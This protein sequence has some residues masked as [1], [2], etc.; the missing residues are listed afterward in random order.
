[1]LLNC[2]VEEDSWEFLG[3]QENKSVL[4]EINPEDS[5]E[6]LVL[7]LKLQ[8]F[9]HLMWRAYSLEKTLILGKTE[10]KR[11]RGQQKINGW[12]ASLTEWTWIWANS[13][14]QWR[15]GEPGMLQF[16]GSQ[17]VGHDLA[18]EQQCDIWFPNSQCL[19]WS[20][21]ELHTGATEDL[22]KVKTL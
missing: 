17:G 15:T 12:M 10:V 3:L 22:T 19:K 14:R 18:T 5:L 20:L 21:V 9:G 1:M 2:G 7:K 8:Y 11:R 13:G 6:G 4:K 16:M